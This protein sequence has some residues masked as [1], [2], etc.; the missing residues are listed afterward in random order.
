M[1]F[2]DTP[3]VRFKRSPLYEVKAQV[4]FPKIL[5]IDVEQ[6]AAFQ[7]EIRDV[8]PIYELRQAVTGPPQIQ[9]IFGGP[10]TRPGASPPQPQ[11]SPASSHV[12]ETADRG[13]GLHL[14]RGSVYLISRRYEGW[15]GFRDRFAGPLNSFI[16]LYKPAFFSHVCLR[17][18]NAIRREQYLLAGTPWSELLQPWVVGPLGVPDVANGVDTGTS[19]WVINL[20]GVKEALEASFSLAIEKPVKN[21]AFLIES[22]VYSNAQTVPTDAITR[23]N[24]LN[25]HAGRFFRSCITERLSGALEPVFDPAQ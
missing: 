13:W 20:P 7:E 21:K 2:A 5:K 3:R 18:K 16:S 8:F 6:P 4:S 11:G 9:V 25:L 24:H 22:H 15:E 17:F 10:G 19:R 14:E 12:F 23:L 1:A